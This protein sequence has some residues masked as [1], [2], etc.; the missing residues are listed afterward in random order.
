MTA[1]DEDIIYYADANTSYFT[2]V[3]M[4]KG[5][6]LEPYLQITILAGPQNKLEKLAN[7]AAGN[8][9]SARPTYTDGKISAWELDGPIAKQ[10]GLKN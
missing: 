10:L 3:V 5:A 9:F 7:N 4:N 1:A 6:G 8:T 2:P